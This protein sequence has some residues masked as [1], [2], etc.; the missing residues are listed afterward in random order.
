MV[1]V[2]ACTAQS[3]PASGRRARCAGA[4][5][6]IGLP[7]GTRVWIAAGHTDM[8][9]GFN[10]LAS[11]MQTALAANL[12]SGHVFIFH[13]RRDDIFKVL[14]SDGQGLLLLATISDGRRSKKRASVSKAT[15]KPSDEQGICDPR[16]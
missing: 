10:G 13:G 1:R 12:H 3:T 15:P 5:L 16:A 2:F 9:K 4:T 11:L 14:W 7:S 6:A 8:R